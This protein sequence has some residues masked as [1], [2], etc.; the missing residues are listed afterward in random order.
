MNRRWV[1]VLAVV[2]A[3]VL[4]VGV[5]VM[6]LTWFLKLAQIQAFA[7]HREAALSRFLNNAKAP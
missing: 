4:V 6:V 7:D 5:A 2:L 1:K 3:G